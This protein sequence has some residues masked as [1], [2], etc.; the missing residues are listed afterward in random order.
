MS[1]GTHLISTDYD[2]SLIVYTTF[3]RCVL[4]LR[5][6]RASK[7][8]GSLQFSCWGE[9]QPG[10]RP[11]LKPYKVY[12]TQTPFSHYQLRCALHLRDACCGAARRVVPCVLRL[13]YRRRVPATGALACSH[14]IAVLALHQNHFAM[15]QR[16]CLRLTPL[17]PRHLAVR[18]G[19]S[20]LPI[21]C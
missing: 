5:L 4:R 17:L 15:Q 11:P 9:V 21:P 16:I 20:S 12:A 18:T 6:S 3:F 10:L 13:T 8:F 1:G 19:C 14:A 2:I 7:T